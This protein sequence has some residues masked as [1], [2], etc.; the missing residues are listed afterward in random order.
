MLGAIFGATSEAP[1][2]TVIINGKK[3][4]QYRGM[5]SLAA[6]AQANG[7]SDRYFQDPHKKLVAEGVEA[8]VPC[9]GSAS[10]IIFELLGGLRS[11]M[12]DEGANDLETLQKEAKFLRIT[13]AS[14]KESHPHDVTLEKES[15]NYWRP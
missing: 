4:K 10:D 5:G 9:K 15:S 12:G 1:G 3:Y 14:L 6:M 2:N 13:S 8:L 7:S 11:G